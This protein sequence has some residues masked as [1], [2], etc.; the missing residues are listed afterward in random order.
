[1]KEK[2]I[3]AQAAIVRILDGNEYVAHV[4]RKIGLI[5]ETISNYYLL[6]I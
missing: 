5:R 6:S 1:M 2:T 4:L 3:G